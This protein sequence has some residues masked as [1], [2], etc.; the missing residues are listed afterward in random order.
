[1]AATTSRI[2]A[3]L[4]ACADRMAVSQSAQFA[5]AQKTAAKI[6]RGAFY[7]GGPICLAA[8]DASGRQ[9][10]SV[11]E[12]TWNNRPAWIVGDAI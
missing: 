8:Y 7:V 4:A 12:S 6:L 9:M 11:A 2:N 3:Q 10:A 1:M 5:I